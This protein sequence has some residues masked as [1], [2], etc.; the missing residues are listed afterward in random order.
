MH[1]LWSILR[2]QFIC[3]PLFLSVLFA[4]VQALAVKVLSETGPRVLES[5][6]LEMQDCKVKKTLPPKNTAI[7]QS[8]EFFFALNTK[9][10]LIRNTKDWEIGAVTVEYTESRFENSPAE[11]NGRY[12]ETLSI[13]PGESASFTL[14]TG[15]MG[16]NLHS[17]EQEDDGKASRAEKIISVAVTSPK[18]VSC[19]ERFTELEL[20]EL[21]EKK[22]QEAKTELEEAKA[23][24][25]RK[26]ILS[27]CIADKL[28]ANSDSVFK[29]S[30]LQ[31]CKR[32][33]ES[34][35]LWNKI[36]Y[37]YLAQ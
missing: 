34:P 31:I 22:Q 35:T 9:A 23:R 19:A 5:N 16:W 12:T 18:I 26:K 8:S 21:E 20:Q 24:E 3:T 7:L 30:I 27:N 6:S 1:L 29:K 32:A 13:P 36:W 2:P 4:P 17:L 15:N 28:P 25:V 37:D 11:F 10:L 14:G 33:S